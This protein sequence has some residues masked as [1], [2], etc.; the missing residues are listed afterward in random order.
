LLQYWRDRAQDAGAHAE[1]MT[2][3]ISKNTL[4]GIAQSYK[5]LAWC[6][7]EKLRDAEQSE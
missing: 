5:F 1:Q 2:D 6:A 3:E 4:R 7:E